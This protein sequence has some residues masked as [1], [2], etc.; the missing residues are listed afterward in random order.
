[1]PARLG[2]GRR[3]CARAG[4][5]ESPREVVVGRAWVGARVEVSNQPGV[6]TCGVRGRGTGGL[7]VRPGGHF[8]EALG[9][10]RRSDVQ[11]SRSTQATGTCRTAATF[12]SATTTL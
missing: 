5:C 7:V 2:E 4:L 6:A 9:S 3:A 8:L 11:H 1:M 12:T 10:A